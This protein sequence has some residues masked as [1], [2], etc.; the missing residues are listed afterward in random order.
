MHSANRQAG[1]G[2]ATLSFALS[3]FIFIVLGFKPFGAQSHEIGHSGERAGYV[4]RQ[5][6]EDS[7]ERSGLNA[8]SLIRI[9]C[10]S[11]ADKEHFPVHDARMFLC[12]N[13]ALDFGVKVDRLTANDTL[14]RHLAASPI[15][16]RSRNW[17]IRHE[18]V[19][20]DA[21]FDWDRISLTDIHK[22]DGYSDETIGPKIPPSPDMSYFEARPMRGSEVVAGGLQEFVSGEP[23]SESKECDE[24]RSNS[25]CRIPSLIGPPPS[26][27]SINARKYKQRMNDF[28]WVVLNFTFCL[29]L[30]FF[31][32]TRLEK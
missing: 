7:A 10:V 32:Y 13:V 24:Y 29:G 9:L 1:I 17:P 12:G 30:L 5:W 26:A 6:V 3:V 15:G 31:I 14:A 11:K 20:L 4:D 21:E 28:W 18:G 19:S 16:R 23:Q 22:L 2:R 27:N 8:P 25:N